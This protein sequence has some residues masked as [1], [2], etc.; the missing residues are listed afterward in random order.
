MDNTYS[1]GG[2]AELM[3][4]P[5]IPVIGRVLQGFKELLISASPPRFPESVRNIT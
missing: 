2:L 5:F 3:Q 1:F 4:E